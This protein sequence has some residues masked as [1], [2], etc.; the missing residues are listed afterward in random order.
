VTQENPAIGETTNLAAC[1]QPLA[2]PNTIVI[3]PETYLLVGAL[4]E[5]RDISPQTLKG[6]RVPLNVRQVVRLRRTEKCFE[7][8]SAAMG[9]PV[10]GCDEELDLL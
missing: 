7:A 5:Y 9:S 1:L 10:R 6:F 2:E 8:R 4:F 3:G